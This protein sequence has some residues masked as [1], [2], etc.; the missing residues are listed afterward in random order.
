MDVRKHSIELQEKSL[1][2]LRKVLNYENTLD[3]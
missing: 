1:I 3:N 2:Y